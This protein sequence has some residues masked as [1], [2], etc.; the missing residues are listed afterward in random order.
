M[1]RRNETIWKYYPQSILALSKEEALQL[2]QFLTKVRHTKQYINLMEIIDLQRYRLI[3][4]TNL[5][6][7]LLSMD[8]DKQKFL[9]LFN[10]N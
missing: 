4:K 10:K 5:I 6:Q 8:F 9:F 3:R 1:L 2:K 7:R